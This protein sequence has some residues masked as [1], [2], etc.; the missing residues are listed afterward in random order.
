[1]K[2]R[3]P[4]TAQKQTEKENTKMKLKDL[5]RGEYFTLKPIAEPKESQ[6][7]IKDEYDR[8]EKKYLC[9][10]FS[11]ISASRLLKPDTTGYTDFTF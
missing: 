5:K 10:K 9:G 11:D 4:N 2:A 7:Y 6:V 3:K 8:S 1:M